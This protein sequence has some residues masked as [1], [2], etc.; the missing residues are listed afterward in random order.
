VVTDCKAVYDVYHWL[1]RPAG[2]AAVAAGTLAHSC[3]ELLAEAME[4]RPDVQMRWM[5]SHRS[6]AE[7]R[8]LGISEE[9]RV[10]N[11]R[12]DQV[13]KDAARWV[14]LPDKL[15]QQYQRRRD[16]AERVAGT[17]GAIQL[18]RLRARIRTADGGAAKV[19]ARVVP[20]LPRRR[21]R[22]GPEEEK[23]T[24]WSGC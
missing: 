6:Q 1:R 19:R 4:A 24:A 12:A 11:E 2:R 9:W 22:S 15:L 14:D 3:W 5:R 10:G 20:G 16:L 21:A 18:Q 7:A 17:V 13:A 23:K 8:A